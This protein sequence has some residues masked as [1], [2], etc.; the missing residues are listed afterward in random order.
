MPHIKINGSTTNTCLALHNTP[1]RIADH[2]VRPRCRCV[3]ACTIRI[4]K[5]KKYKQKSHHTNQLNANEI[6]SGQLKLALPLCE[7]GFE[8]TTMKRLREKRETNLQRHRIKRYTDDRCAAKSS[9]TSIC[10]V[11]LLYFAPFVSSLCFCLFRCCF[12]FHSR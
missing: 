11:F 4:E 7:C 5:K 6:F 2:R 12:S 3:R 8:T 1:H 10:I 9:F